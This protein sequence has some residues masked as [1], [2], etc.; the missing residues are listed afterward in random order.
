MLDQTMPEPSTATTRC[1]YP[2]LRPFRPDEAD[3]LFGRD[4]QIRELRRRLELSRF[5]A[6]V[7][8][9][10]CGKSSLILAGLIPEIEAGFLTSAGS[11]W[12]V[13]TFRPGS[14]PLTNL[15]ATLLNSGA[16]ARA[17]EIEGEDVALIEAA[18]RRGPLGLV[19]LYQS[20]HD[21]SDENLLLVV[22]Q[23]EELFRFRKTEETRDNADNPVDREEATA[24]VAL[25]LRTVKEKNVRIYVI[26]TMR[27]DFLGDCAFFANLPE[28]LNE[29]Q[30][31]TPRLSFDQRREAIEAPARVEEGRVDP[32]LSLRLLN[33]MGT[34]PDQLPL[35]QHALMRVWS[36]AHARDPSTPPTLTLADYLE[37]GGLEQ[38]LSRHADAAYDKLTDAQKVIAERL[39][40]ALTGGNSGRRDT[41]RPTKLGLIADMAGVSPEAVAEVVKFFRGGDLNLLTPAQGPLVRDTTID[42]SHESLIRQW[43]KLKDWVKT[44]ANSAETYRLLEQTAAR[45]SEREGGDLWTGHNLSSVLAW[46]EKEKPN[47]SWASRYGDGF[48]HAL[49]FIEASKEKRRKDLEER[50]LAEQRELLSK[51]RGRLAMAAGVALV[52]V[53]GFAF[54]A[55]AERNQAQKNFVAAR[56]AEKLAKQE[57]RRA[58]EN[59]ERANQ[60][61]KDASMKRALAE[62]QTDLAN[63]LILASKAQ[64][65][66]TGFPVLS[67]L[68]TS[69]ALKTARRQ[70]QSNVEAENVLRR[71][72][73][74]IGGVSLFDNRGKTGFV[75]GVA[76]SPDG[77]SLIASRYVGEDNG[78]ITL[79]DVASRKRLAGE[80]LTVK[81]GPIERN[82][83]FSTDGKTIAAGYHFGNRDTSGVVLW[84]VVTRKRLTEDPLPI[85][86]GQ[87]MGVAFSPD[88]KT[89]AA[90]YGSGG[91][92]HGGVVLWDVATRKRLSV[93]PLTVTEGDVAAVAFSPDGK[94]VAAGIY[95]ASTFAAG[96]V[97]LWDVATRKRLVDNPLLVK[98]GLVTSV[99]FSPDG[100]TI[101]AGYFDLS[102][103]NF[104][105]VVLWDVAT[106]KRLVEGALP[107]KE[108]VLSVAFSP[109]GKTIAAGFSG[110]GEGGVVLWN[111]AT[112]NR[113]ADSPIPVKE[114]VVT[115]VA[116][117]PDGKTL[118]AGGGAGIRLWDLSTPAPAVSEPI[119][120]GN[121]N[122]PLQ[123]TVA[124]SRD[125]RWIIEASSNRARLWATLSTEGINLSPM[126]LDLSAISTPLK[127]DPLPLELPMPKMLGIT[128]STSTPSKADPRP[129]E[130]AFT[131]DGRRVFILGDKGFGVWNCANSAEAKPYYVSANPAGAAYRSPVTS[132]DGRWLCLRSGAS[133]VLLFDLDGSPAPFTRNLGPLTASVKDEPV[134]AKGGV[135][136]TRFS[137]NQSS[138]ILSGSTP[139]D[140]VRPEAPG[141]GTAFSADHRWLA[142]TDRSKTIVV[143]DL[144]AKN[145]AETVFLLEA[146]QVV[147]GVAFHPK[148]PWLFAAFPNPVDKV[149][150]LVSWKLSHDERKWTDD[151]SMPMEPAPSTTSP[152]RSSEI[153]ILD[154]SPD[155][156]RLSIRR[157]GCLDIVV[158]PENPN[159]RGLSSTTYAD[160]P[161]TVPL[162]YSLDS[163]WLLA[164]AHGVTSQLFALKNQPMSLQASPGVSGPGSM[165]DFSRDSRWLATTG[166]DDTLSVWDLKLIGKE[167]S[168][169]ESEPFPQGFGKPRSPDESDPLPR[170][171]PGLARPMRV[172]RFDAEARRLVTVAGDGIIRVWTLDNDELLRIAAR[173]AGR[174]LT[175][176]EWNQYFPRQEY[177]RTFE[178][179]AEPGGEAD[180]PSSA[181]PSKS[182]HPR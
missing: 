125:G 58:N 82:M 143:W 32:D 1:P 64:N 3:L 170:I 182:A 31:L 51:W 109:D 56:N 57:E 4:E 81:D 140:E 77:Q 122:D 179:F 135:L 167:R 47:E 8:E 59:A 178:E 15:A 68:L 43:G 139:T 161:S 166:N 96:G 129:L 39:F 100:K 71:T 177:R 19:E 27:S 93:D 14:N 79:W 116:F 163:S 18:L 112:R 38:A 17:S 22:D 88:V 7:G 87:I 33:D 131:E 126:V 120:L 160:R 148:M 67:I 153:A 55:F 117:S 123:G 29:G 165:A 105:G 6:V 150:R 136:S 9:S 24:F 99:A 94:T 114:G 174:N 176:Q 113:R 137:G 118:A 104:G 101:A 37:V 40:R 152:L 52:V 141:V 133:R 103:F 107:V 70:N 180:S 97:V 155:G 181:G 134:P 53:M 49:R 86:E 89:V 173:T 83:A 108:G 66:S 144:Q 121:A 147:A 73:G 130:T 75:Y 74:R 159:D 41:R 149:F 78:A 168:S 54:W 23:F 110:D 50:I 76:F 142:T 169:D 111:V 127:S 20:S 172:V 46:L 21:R 63:S 28:A 35:M 42:I 5:L 106:R 16:L 60:N 62:R 90:G 48:A 80:S 72:L 45:W 44:E 12:T 171:F 65:L 132:P 175:R 34:G 95:S 30:F 98:E 145:P 154:F 158:L 85:K 138:R 156:S 10:G 146:K 2:G 26:L 69:E 164:P 102:N 124:A 91:S 61:A 84:D 162:Q 13:A 151:L 36:M 115:G 11:S 128:N 119:Y 92:G 157:E 25:L